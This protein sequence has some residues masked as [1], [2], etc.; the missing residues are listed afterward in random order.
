MS[1]ELS[2]YASELIIKA[3]RTLLHRCEFFMKATA[4]CYEFI[5]STTV[6]SYTLVR[7]NLGLL[8]ETWHFWMKLENETSQVQSGNAS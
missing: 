2:D 6:L 1:P 3:T 4:L 8:S 5:M 7:R